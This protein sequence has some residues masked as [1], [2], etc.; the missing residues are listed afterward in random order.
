MLR[1]IKTLLTYLRSRELVTPL[2]L[3]VLFLSCT[4]YV[5]DLET[6][7]IPELDREVVLSTRRGFPL[8]FYYDPKFLATT[9]ALFPLGLIIDLAFWLIISYT[10]SVMAGKIMG[11]RR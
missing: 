10:L 9:P 6:E 7:F 4:W 8:P 11:K 2:V 3:S 5:E 1:G